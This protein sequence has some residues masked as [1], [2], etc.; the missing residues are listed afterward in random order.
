MM[1]NI[2][3]DQFTANIYQED[4]KQK[5]MGTSFVYKMHIY[6]KSLI[7]TL[8]IINL[9]DQIELNFHFIMK[10]FNLLSIKH[11]TDTETSL[12]W[13]RIKYCFNIRI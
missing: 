3:H 1:H 8:E 10:K 2:I 7:F 9:V 12:G 13:P 11:P 6:S 4:S 5:V